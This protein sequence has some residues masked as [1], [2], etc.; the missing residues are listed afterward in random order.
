MRT[1]PHLLPGGSD[2][3]DFGDANA[4]VDPRFGAADLSSMGCV[5]GDAR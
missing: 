1:M 2:E 4:V 5:F 3:A